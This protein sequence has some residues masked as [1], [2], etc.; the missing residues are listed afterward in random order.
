MHEI[1]NEAEKKSVIDL[2]YYFHAVYKTLILIT[3]N[4]NN[5]NIINI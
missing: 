1:I 3:I 5:K 4:C 2:S